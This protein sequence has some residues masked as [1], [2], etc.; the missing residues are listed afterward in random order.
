M[1]ISLNWIKEYIPG[2]EI[3]PIESF[4]EKMIS[5]GLD[6]EHVEIQSDVYKNFVVGEVM[7]KI[8][9]PKA[10]KLSLCRV[11][12]GSD[13]LSVVC[14]APNVEAGQKVC[15]ALA[16]AIIPNGGF[17]IKKSKIRGEVS[18]GMICS[19]SE[20]NLSDNHDGIKVLDKDAAAG[21]K[22]SDYLN[23]NDMIF[24]IG[25]TPNRGDLLSHFGIA[26]EIAALFGKKIKI[27]DVSITESDTLTS[28][29]I[30][31]E[32]KNE[33]LCRRFTGRV[34]KNTAIKESPEW[35]KR[36]LTSVGLRPR[37]NI[38]DITNFVMFETGQPLHAFDYDKIRGKKIIIK[39]AKAGDKFITLDS[40]ERILNENSL[41]VCDSEGYSGIAG[42]M[43]GEFSEITNE[44]KNVFIES[45]YFDPVSI[46][47]NSKQLGLKTD[48]SIRFERGVD[49]NKVSYASD[50][51][52]RLIQETAG[53]EV[54]K[55]LLDVY[56]GKQEENIVGIRA[57]KASE[58][59]GLNLNP[60]IIKQLLTKIEIEFVNKS[61]GYLFFRIPEFRR[62]DLEREADLIEEAARIYGYDNIEEDPVFS[63]NVSGSSEKD[64]KDK[65]L[66]NVITN[67]LIGRGFNQIF[68][69]T[70][71]DFE[72]LR[73][74]GNDKEVVRLK[75]SISAG[76]DALRN[77]F[78]F[79]IFK[80]VRSN[81]FH[82]GK[83]IPIKFFEIGRVFRDGGDKFI[84]EERLMIVMSG[85]K[86]NVRFFSGEEWFDLFD[87]KG[88][89]EM[90]LS[91]LNLENYRLFYYNDNNFDDVRID[92]SLNDI[93][94]GTINKADRTMRKEFEIEN[95]VYFGEIFLDKIKDKITYNDYYREISRYPSVKRDLAIVVS[96]KVTYD[97]LK[98]VIQKSGG[99]YIKSIELF[100]L[101]RDEKLGAD[102]KSLAFSLEFVSVDRTLTDDE[103]NKIMNSII[104]ELETEFGAKLRE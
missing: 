51:A 50:R 12:T 31:I 55:N 7:E 70:L 67:H 104:K 1:K 32:I 89:I 36:R 41:M 22:F 86:D 43:G 101:Y 30:E 28:E 19:E 48:A 26:R 21:T 62:L 46:R 63:F 35:L 38:V 93:V 9:H 8:K 66:F 57:E 10:D 49:I 72:K 52:A 4:T 91:K 73:S 87:I 95:D 82:S 84:E 20:L 23:L 5:A 47:L 83:D 69:K 15:V 96:E 80:A 6:I 27:P 29:L 77:D 14:G 68:T 103:T 75:N 45:A 81:F 2:L 40:K 11:N 33:N 54:S 64:K 71:V 42:V 79:E 90:L 17:E 25:I 37:N 18:E 102:K 53:G 56:P 59:L 94:I 92:I 34:I 3:G 13:V 76:L 65:T 85:R 60:E 98:Y 16:G 100:D 58:L 44:T 61:G 88:E 74:Y 39:T 99:S 97:D 78:T 24:E